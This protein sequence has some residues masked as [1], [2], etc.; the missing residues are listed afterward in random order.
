MRR[1]RRSAGRARV[2]TAACLVFAG[3]GAAAWWVPED[4]THAV[5]N[6][7]APVSGLVSS[8]PSGTRTVP[9]ARPEQVV[10]PLTASVPDGAVTQDEGQTFLEGRFTGRVLDSSGQPVADAR[11]HVIPNNSI[12]KKLGLPDLSR[13][14]LLGDLDGL[15]G[16]AT[17][18]EMPTTL[19]DEQGRFDLAV[20][21]PAP[22]DYADLKAWNRPALEPT[23]LVSHAGFVPSQH[24]CNSFG[25]E[26]HDLGDWT[27]I[28]GVEVTGRVVNEAGLGVADVPVAIRSFPTSHS[29]D[30]EFHGMFGCGGVRGVQHVERRWFDTAHELFRARTDAGGA[31][32]IDGVSSGTNSS[33]ELT[34]QP[35]VGLPVTRNISSQE[36][37]DHGR[38]LLADIV[39]PSAASLGGHVIDESGQAVAGATVRLAI[40]RFGRGGP[41]SVHDELHAVTEGRTDASRAYSEQS[42]DAALAARFFTATTD[43]DGHFLVAGLDR[44]HYGVYAEA[45]GREPARTLDVRVGRNDVRLVLR[46]QSSYLLRFVDGSGSARPLEWMWAS[47]EGTR[48]RLRVEGRPFA[49]GVFLLEDVCTVGRSLSVGIKDVGSWTVRLDGLPFGSGRHER[50]LVLEP[51]AE[52]S[53][54]VAGAE[55]HMLKR[56]TVRLRPRSEARVETLHPTINEV[57]GFDSWFTTTTSTTGSVIARAAKDGSWHLSADEGAYDLH[58]SATGFVAR[59]APLELE[60]GV[61]LSLPPM[62]LQRQGRVDV[63]VLLGSVQAASGWVKLRPEDPTDF[64]RR[65]GPLPRRQLKS[66]RTSFN[67]P[68]AGAYQVVHGALAS[69][70]D[71]LAESWIDVAD[72]RITTVQLQ[73]AGHLRL[74]GRITGL[75][76]WNRATVFAQALDGSWTRST[77]SD[78]TGRY[79]MELPIAAAAECRVQAE[80][81]RGGLSPE[82]DVFVTP[83]RTAVVDFR[84]TSVGL[85]LQGTVVDALTGA[86]L[87]DVEVELRSATGRATSEVDTDASGRFEFPS[88]APLG[89]ILSVHSHGFLAS[90]EYAMDSFEAD[91]TLRL[92]PRALLEGTLWTPLRDPLAG[93]YSVVLY[94]RQATGKL[95]SVDQATAKRGDFEL[96]LAGRG[97]Y[98][99]LVMPYWSMRIPPSHEFGEFESLASAT[100]MVE[101]GEPTQVELVIGP[102]VSAW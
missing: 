80:A 4:A 26:T 63:E 61:T 95:T 28:R 5:V 64:A 42:M 34:V 27:L 35:N 49:S 45:P 84:F 6:S 74:E 3:L 65:H 99:V 20:S 44:Q 53:G 62:V 37:P 25:S 12:A 102:G 85:P 78:E 88:S 86:P 39:L 7:V 101:S 38:H 1:K 8:L 83:G 14:V 92:E 75:R 58:V 60:S 15:D 36:L 68:E 97:E 19:S 48:E 93:V 31:F 76:G 40:Q 50:T 91:I 17:L 59:V 73:R 55:G 24:S 71:V 30:L 69:R 32:R 46:T 87:N 96:K 9:V 82:V 72:G 98:V 10:L 21:Y 41:E 18:T 94:R 43:D 81:P 52:L 79:L 70:D 100:L 66:G 22:E 13:T 90:A 56:A 16:M 33:R 2:G 57:A 29:C 54:Q 89:S 67:L 23:L 11:V 77:D 51:K 47:R